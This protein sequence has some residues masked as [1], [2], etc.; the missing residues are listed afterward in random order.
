[1]MRLPDPDSEAMGLLVDRWLTALRD[2]GYGPQR[3]KRA[4]SRLADAT[5]GLSSGKPLPPASARV[6]RDITR[7]MEE[8][9]VAEEPPPTP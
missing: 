8:G 6:L 5:E 2:A 7:F 3:L 9:T 1:M 4:A